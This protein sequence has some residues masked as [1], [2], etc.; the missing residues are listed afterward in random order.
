M[1]VV[2]AP[3]I[4]ACCDKRL[5]DSIFSRLLGEM[6]LV[7][8]GFF[9]LRVLGGALSLNNQGLDAI[10]ACNA[11][12]FYSQLE[13]LVAYG[14]D[15][16]VITVHGGEC[17]E[18]INNFGLYEKGIAPDE[19]AAILR[20]WLNGALAGCRQR[21]TGIPVIPFFIPGSWLGGH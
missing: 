19:E 5:N 15:A 20:E 10:Q 9:S 1:S 13:R 2:K 4:V 18:A 3:L 17:L 21:I 14:A 7:C 8:P 12:T 16:L 6:G 11:L